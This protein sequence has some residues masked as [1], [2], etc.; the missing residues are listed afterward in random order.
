[1]AYVYMFKYIIVGDS[2]V[3]K[4]CLL[5]NFTD[6]RFKA[7]HEVTIGVEFGSKTVV[8]DKKPIKIQIWDT[9]GQES[10]RSIT[11]AYYRGATGALLVYDVS[12]RETFNHLAQWIE[13]VRRY[14]DSKMVIMLVGN[15]SDLPRHEVTYEDGAQFAK[16]NGLMFIET[17]A[18]T[19]DHVDE[20]FL[21]TA[22]KIYEHIQSGHYD[23]SSQS[24][25]IK[26]GVPN[27]M[28]NTGNEFKPQ[29]EVATCQC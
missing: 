9:A 1:M 23:I 19:A 3:G 28:L 11:R 2:A 14:A 26:V 8:V 24:H 21:G 27:K 13:D 7:G 20:A 5:L 16:D 25:G 22:E 29:A 12:R 18:K 15:K 17:S 10:F 6:K 4:S